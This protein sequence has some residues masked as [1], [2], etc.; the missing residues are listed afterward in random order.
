MND[1]STYQA[2][3]WDV[4]QALMTAIAIGLGAAV[5][6]SEGMRFIVFTLLMP[7]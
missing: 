2:R 1:D 3:I 6:L 7:E 5:I 4:T